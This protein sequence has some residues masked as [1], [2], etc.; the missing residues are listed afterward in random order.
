MCVVYGEHYTVGIE[1]SRIVVAPQNRCTV[2]N[3]SSTV[4]HVSTS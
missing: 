2:V 4:M 1:V 3:L